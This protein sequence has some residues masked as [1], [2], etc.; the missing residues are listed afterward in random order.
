MYAKR[1]HR[2]DTAGLL[3]KRADS[4]VAAS[5]SRANLT[6]PTILGKMEQFEKI[7][8]KLWNDDNVIKLHT[9]SRYMREQQDPDGDV[10]NIRENILRFPH[11]LDSLEEECRLADRIE[12]IEEELHY[13][14]YFA[15]AE[16]NH[17]IF[18]NKITGDTSYR[19]TESDPFPVNLTKGQEMHPDYK[20]FQIFKS[21][22]GTLDQ[23][24]KEE[25]DL[26]YDN[27]KKRIEISKEALDDYVSDINKHIQGYRKQEEKARNA[28]YN[29]SKEDRPSYLEK[30]E[31]YQGSVEELERMLPMEMD[32]EE[33]PAVSDSGNGNKTVMPGAT[34]FGSQPAGG[35]QQAVGAGQSVKPPRYLDPQTWQ[36]IADPQ[37][38]QQVFDTETKQ[39]TVYQGEAH[40]ISGSADLAADSESAAGAAGV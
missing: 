31:F 12:S 24:M 15:L 27:L 40:Q 33:Q 13:P 17:M 5:V 20:D 10:K 37:P 9:C 23:D 6:A 7:K 35:V 28:M 22:C 19:R 14:K 38:G 1:D 16:I 2:P 26:Q 21:F 4:K 36:P 25:I 11:I 32:R 29:A 18:T 8:A 30:I 39:M 3:L 34:V